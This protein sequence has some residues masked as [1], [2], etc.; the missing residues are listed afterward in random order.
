MRGMDVYNRAP[1]EF[2]PV[3]F[4]RLCGFVAGDALDASV[5]HYCNLELSE[6]PSPSAPKRELVRKADAAQ[7]ER[8]AIPADQKGQIRVRLLNATPDPLGSVAA[9][10]EQYKGNVVR[11]LSEVTDEQRRAAL[12][13]MGKT[14]LN[15]PLE[16]AQFHWQIEGLTRST[17]HQLVRARA[18]FIAQESL[19]FAVPE[20]RWA[21]EI[22]LPPSIAGID[23]WDEEQVAM[24]SDSDAYKAYVVWSSTMDALERAY[25]RLIELGMPAEE[26]RGALPHSMPT[27][28]HWITDL[29]TLLAEAGKRTC[30]QAEFPWRMIFAGM[31]QQ[32]RSACWDSNPG[33]PI[34]QMVG[35]ERARAMDWQFKAIADRLR[36]VCFQTGECG[37]MAKFDRSCNIRERVEKLGPRGLDVPTSGWN[38]PRVIEQF[39]N[40]QHP[41][42]IMSKADALAITIP[43]YDW[44]ANPAAARS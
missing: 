2:V 33:G 34:T 16:S 35:R 19:R 10:I 11:S 22:P 9:L 7:Y 43:D 3:E 36:P 28:L 25:A 30:T 8:E 4:S 1:H 40:A 44:A 13:E 26:A 37:F 15:G 39:Y 41:G 32:L 17:S 23:R 21:D 18:T 14:V 31:A 20:G 42:S 38:N 6:H 24:A 12:D 5:E 29:R 27:R